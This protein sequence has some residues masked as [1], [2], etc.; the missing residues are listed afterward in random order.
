[1]DK[2]RTF[3]VQSLIATARDQ[4]TWGGAPTAFPGDV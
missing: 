3:A 1:M 4:L 2:V